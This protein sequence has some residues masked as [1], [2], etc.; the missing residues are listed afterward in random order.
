[1][2]SD[3]LFIILG[4]VMFIIPLFLILAIFAS[5][6]KK[7][8]PDEAMVVFGRK[9]NPR[10]RIGYQVIS[11]GG[12][13]ILPIIEDHASMPI[14]VQELV[15]EMDVDR[16]PVGAPEDRVPFKATVLYKVSS[17][18]DRLNCAC[19]HLLGKSPDEIDTMARTVIEGM[20]RSWLRYMMK[21][22]FDRDWD[23]LSTSLM[24]ASDAELMNIGYEVKSFKIH[25]FGM[26]G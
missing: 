9:M 10:S 7:V 18:P 3:S 13:F 23:L 1:M 24:K 4:M 22:E 15:I 20:T 6:Y 17:E 16:A 2:A 26:G 12:K 11:G 5:R 14:R 19:E 25:A 8:P 21:E